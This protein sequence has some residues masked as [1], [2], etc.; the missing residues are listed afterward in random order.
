MRH[1]RHGASEEGAAMVNDSEPA[2]ED[3]DTIHLHE[4]GRREAMGGEESGRTGAIHNDSY[5]QG[6][7]LTAYVGS[8]TEM[9]RHMDLDDVYRYLSKMRDW[10]VDVPALALQTVGSTPLASLC[11]GIR[12]PP[13]SPEQ[14]EALRQFVE[15]NVGIPYSHEQHWCDLERLWDISFP[16]TEVKPEQHDAQWKRLGFQGMDAATDFRSAGVLALRVLMHF[17][18][19]RTDGDPLRSFDEQRRAPAEGFLHSGRQRGL[20]CP[21]F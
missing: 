10:L 1:R 16:Q 12:G 13:L 17:A 5:G 7:T 18:E 21:N 2:G 14:Q 19:V 15:D 4:N 9:L 8:I 3:D 11:F 6:G 20:F